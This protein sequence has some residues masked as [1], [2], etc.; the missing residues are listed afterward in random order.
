MKMFSYS[1]HSDNDFGNF[2][3]FVIFSLVK[4]TFSS[5]EFI[6]LRIRD[7]FFLQIFAL[8]TIFFFNYLFEILLSWLKEQHRPFLCSNIPQTCCDFGHL[9]FLVFTQL[10]NCVIHYFNF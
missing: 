1:K 5:V 6:I 9:R 2:S 10:F 4:N 8:V 7:N 3:K